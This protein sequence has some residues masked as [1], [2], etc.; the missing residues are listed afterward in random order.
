MVISVITALIARATLK[1][2]DSNLA[3]AAS[4]PSAA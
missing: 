1:I 4:P 3:M 2:T